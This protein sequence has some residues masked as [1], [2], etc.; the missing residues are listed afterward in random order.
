M[1]KRGVRIVRD[2][3]V[4]Q[5]SQLREGDQLSAT[6]ITAQ[7]PRVVT[8]Q[9]VNATLAAAK[10]TAGA[11]PARASSGASAGTAPQAAATP[12][13]TTG[14][15]STSGDARALPKTASA[16]PLLWL[17]SVLSLAIGFALTIRRRLVR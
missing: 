8:E 12:Q 6:I 4:V 1:D 11:A 17:A 7:P 13:A 9:E 3:K 10:T 16:W 5:L 14:Q 15:A 2:G